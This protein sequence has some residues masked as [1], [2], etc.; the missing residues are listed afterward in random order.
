MIFFASHLKLSLTKPEYILWDLVARILHD[1]VDMM[2][3][4]PYGIFDAFIVIAMS[5][6][7]FQALYHV[8]H[9]SQLV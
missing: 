4:L 3:D 8:Q 5:Q 7:S 1:A 2:F 9:T 6:H